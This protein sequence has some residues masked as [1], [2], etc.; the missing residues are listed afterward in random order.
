MISHA[1]EWARKQLNEERDFNF[2]SLLD[3]ID[4][5][6]KSAEGRI[7]DK[8]INDHY[9]DLK[10]WAKANGYVK[11]SDGRGYATKNYTNLD[12]DNFKW[13]DSNGNKLYT[14][15]EIEEVYN[16]GL[17]IGIQTEKINS[18]KAIKE[19]IEPLEKVNPNFQGSFEAAVY[20]CLAK[21]KEICGEK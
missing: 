4:E 8:L 12:N 13:E 16:K 3:F 7:I 9:N 21:A 19:V 20:K 2:S 6:E 5:L 14:Q 15:S 11:P 1:K 18:V 10:E 17:G